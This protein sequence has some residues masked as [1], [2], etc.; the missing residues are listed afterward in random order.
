MTRHGTVVYLM[1]G[2]EVTEDG[3]IIASID[4]VW[5]GELFGD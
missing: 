4:D 1:G 2:R 5:A 3:K